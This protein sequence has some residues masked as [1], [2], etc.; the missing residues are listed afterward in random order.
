M[1]DILLA[2]EEVVGWFGEL[3]VEAK[4]RGGWQG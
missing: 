2:M 1:K 4:E 3:I